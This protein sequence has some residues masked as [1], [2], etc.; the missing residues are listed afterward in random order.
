M[1]HLKSGLDHGPL[2]TRMAILPKSCSKRFVLANVV[3]IIGLLWCS[4][5]H[6]N[7]LNIWS[8]QRKSGNSS[9]HCIILM[10]CCFCFLQIQSS[11]YLVSLVDNNY[12]DGN[13]FGVFEDLWSW[14]FRY[15]HAAVFHLWNLFFYLWFNVVFLL[16]YLSDRAWIFIC[17]FICNN[18]YIKR[19]K[20]T[21]K[22]KTNIFKWRP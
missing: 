4:L 18:D 21:N 1:K 14:D 6:F 8:K 13:I 7:C 5:L 22:K 3:T 15:Y 17:N 20:W 10:L 16:Y 11:Y 19:R 12:M 9:K 2:C